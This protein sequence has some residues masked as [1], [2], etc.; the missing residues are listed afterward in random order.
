MT[1]R[2]RRRS[3]A[4]WLGDSLRDIEAGRRA[5]MATVFDHRMMPQVPFHD[6]RA[7]DPLADICVHSL[8]ELVKSAV[9]AWLTTECRHRYQT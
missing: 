3:A 6:E 8:A 4:S 1:F 5:G 2:R 9:C 7:R